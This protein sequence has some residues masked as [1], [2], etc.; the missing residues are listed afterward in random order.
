VTEPTPAVEAPAPSAFRNLVLQWVLP[1]LAGVALFVGVGW[2]RAPSLPEQAPGFALRDLN[3]ELVKLDDLRGRTVVLNFWATW[4]APCRAEIPT[5]SA[6]A[7]RHPEVSVLGLVAD[8]PVGKVRAA[9]ADFGVTYPVLMTDRA[10]LDAYG[11]NTFPTTV[12][13]APDGRVTTAHTGIMFRP[14]LAWAVF[15]RPW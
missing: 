5:F 10:T 7:Q 15:R 2:L 13:V 11:V 9:S 4:C 3:G 14:Q 8:G 12:V 6:F 1:A